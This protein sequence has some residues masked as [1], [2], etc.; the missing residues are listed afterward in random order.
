MRS[1][2]EA[3]SLAPPPRLLSP[4]LTCLPKLPFL[5]ACT[6]PTQLPLWWEEGAHRRGSESHSLLIA[7]G[8]L[9]CAEGFSHRLNLFLTAGSF[10]LAFKHARGSFD[11]TL[12]QPWVPLK[13]GP[14]RC[15]SS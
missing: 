8:A 10:L 1:A 13:L 11:K 15:F 9:F 2:P 14:H 5:L 4:A 12:F 6:S 3:L 7:S